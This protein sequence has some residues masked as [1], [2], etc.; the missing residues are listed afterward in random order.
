VNKNK[1]T[2]FFSSTCEQEVKAEVHSSLQIPIE[3]LGE[4]YLGLPTIAGKDHSD[5]FKYVPARV[6]G[7][8]GGWAEK[9]LS[10]AAREVLLKA[11]AQS[12]PTYPMLCFKLP[13]A[14]QDHI[15]C[16]KLLVGLLF[17]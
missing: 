16:F 10:C 2:V 17:G 11:N 4:R 1:S 14:A 9:S 13:P 8:V 12:V 15:G 6:W 5:A 3:A 7:F